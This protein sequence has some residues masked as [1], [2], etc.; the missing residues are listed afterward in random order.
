[1]VRLLL[2]IGLPTRVSVLNREPMWLKC[3][4][5]IVELFTTAVSV[6]NREPMWLKSGSHPDAR[7]G[8]RRFSAQP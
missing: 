5:K 7:R 2:C 1:M 3:A 8:A 4:G 6:L